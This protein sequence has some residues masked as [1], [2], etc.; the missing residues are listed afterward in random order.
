MEF[1]ILI[2]K[3]IMK[4]LSSWSICVETW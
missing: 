3:I 2:H 1:P 4:M